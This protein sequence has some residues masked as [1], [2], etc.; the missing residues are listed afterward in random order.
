MD[1]DKRTRNHSSQGGLLAKALSMGQNGVGCAQA[2]VEEDGVF[3]IQESLETAGVE[4][5]PGL[6][7]LVDSVLDVGSPVRLS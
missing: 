7:A 2:I 3:S 4:L 1:M 5:D 6:K